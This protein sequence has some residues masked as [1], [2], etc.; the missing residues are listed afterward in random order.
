MPEE[1][2]SA[3]EVGK[4]IAEHLEKHGHHDDARSRRISIVEAVLLASVALIAAW[5]GFAAAEWS[6]EP[7]LE[8]AQS[9]RHRILSS[10]ASLESMESTNFDASTFNA[11]FTAWVAGDE[12]AQ[13]IAERRFSD[14]FQVAFDAWIATDPLNN[15]DAPKGPTFMPEYV[16]PQDVTYEEEARLA[17]EAYEAG[18][19][20]GKTADDYVRITV[21]L[22]SVLF[23]IGISGHFRI[24]AARVGLVSVSGLILTYAVILLIQAPKP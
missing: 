12:A 24:H 13:E 10:E 19:E 23:L 16:L 20:A 6:T 1:G 3:A 17:D 4:E 7:R 9:S 15:P 14:E 22:A 18:A 5:S 21:L 2:L 8:L 11:W